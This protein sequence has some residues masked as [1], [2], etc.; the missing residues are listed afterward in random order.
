M[1]GFAASWA[2]DRRFE[3]QM[4]DDT[5]KAR[6]KGWKRAVERTLS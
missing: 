4:D 3:P 2:R 5:R 6:L 1:D